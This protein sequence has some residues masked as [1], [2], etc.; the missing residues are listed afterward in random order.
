MSKFFKSM[1]LLLSAGLFTA[2]GWADVMYFNRLA[3]TGSIAEGTYRDLTLENP[4]NATTFA[5]NTT[6]SNTAESGEIGGSYT[7]LLVSGVDITTHTFMGW[8]KI[9]ALPTSGYQNLWLVSNTQGTYGG[10]KAAVTPEGKIAF[11]RSGTGWGFNDSNTPYVTTTEVCITADTW[12]HIALVFEKSSSARTATC[13]LYVNGREVSL[14][15]SFSDTGCN[16]NASASV[17]IA[18]GVSAAGIY[19][20][21]TVMSLDDIKATAVSE[22]Y[23]RYITSAVSTTLSSN[24]DWSTTF[25]N[26]TADTDLTVNVDG[27]VTLTVNATATVNSLTVNEGSADGE[28]SLIIANTDANKLT[29]TTTTINADT[30]VEAGAASLGVATIA[31][32]KT[33][34]VKEG[35]FT[36]NDNISNGSKLA[37]AGTVALNLG[38]ENGLTLDGNG[39]GTFSGAV[40]VLSGTLTMTGAGGSGFLTGRTV[41]VLDGAA[42]TI[43]DDN[44]TGHGNTPANSI[45]HVQQGGTLN[46]TSR[47]SFKSTL[48]LTGGAVNLTGGD[49]AVGGIK[50]TLDWM[51]DGDYL[52]VA[53]LENATAETPTVSK[54]SQKNDCGLALRSALGIVVEAKAKL[55]IEAPIVDVSAGAVT[56][57]GL[58]VLEL[59]G[60]NTS[61]HDL[62]VEAGQM[63]LSGAW[64]GALSVNAEA[65]LTYTTSAA[66]TNTITNNNNGTITA[67]AATV[68]LTGATISGNG[69]YGVTNGGTLILK[70]G[71]ENGA[72]VTRGTLKLLLSPEQLI[73]G[74]TADVADGTVVTF[75]KVK[76]GAEEY[77]TLAEGVTKYGLPAKD[78]L[79]LTATVGTGDGQVTAWSG[80]A[81]AYVYKNTTLSIHFTANNQTFTFDNT[82]GVSLTSLTVTAEDGVTGAKIV[83]PATEGLVIATA[84]TINAD[85]TVTGKGALG[86]VT[87]AEG[88]TLTVSE[89]YENIISSLTNNGSLAFAGTESAPLQYASNDGSVMSW[90]KYVATHA[91]TYTFCGYV[92]VEG[93]YSEGS[94]D[95]RKGWLRFQA[96]PQTINIEDGANITATRL[97]ASDG[98]NAATTINQDGGTIT[99]KSTVV[100]GSDNNDTTGN[101][102]LLGHWP[103]TTTYNLNAG[104]LL[105][106]DGAL[107]LGWDGPAHLTIGQDSGNKPALVS[108]KRLSG[109]TRS[110]DAS[111]TIKRTGTL[112]I[113]DRGIQLASSKSFT[114]AGGTLEMAANMAANNEII[115]L[116]HSAGLK[117]TKD[118]TIVVVENVKIAYSGKI[119]G[120]SNTLTKMGA[121][122]LNLVNASG[123]DTLNYVVNGGT[124][125][126]PAG[127][128]NGASVTRGTLKLL[129][130]PELLAKG[131]TANVANG[132]TVTFVVAGNADG[133]GDGYDT[134][135]EGVA[136]N[137]Y[138]AP[139]NVWTPSKDATWANTLNWSNEALPSDT[140]NVEIQIAEDTTLVLPGNVTVAALR[141]T[142]TG[143]LTIT[144][145]KLTASFID[146]QAN[147]SA[148]EATLALVPMEISENVRVTYTMTTADV[149]LPAM[150]GAGTF[151]KSGNVTTQLNS[152]IAYPATIEV[153]EGKLL[154]RD[155]TYALASHV[156]AKE[157]TTVQVGTLAAN[158]TASAST[159]R[160]EGGATLLLENG[161]TNG[162]RNVATAITID[163]SIAG[164]PAVIKGSRQGNQANITGPISGKGVLEILQHHNSFTI[165]GVISDA[166][167]TETLAVKVNTSVGVTFSGSNTYTGGTEIATGAKLTTAIASLP[168]DITLQEGAVLI[169]NTAAGTATDF[170]TRTITVTPSETVGDRALIVRQNALNDKSTNTFVMSGV[171][172][173]GSGNLVLA[174]KSGNASTPVF[175]TLNFAEGTDFS[176]EISV[177]NQFDKGAVV[178]VVGNCL[179][180]ATYTFASVNGYNA[181]TGGSTF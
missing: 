1:F 75:V 25:Q 127:K 140:D 95:A 77:E 160:L 21:S 17:Y 11:G 22:T 49:N 157:G 42:V 36:N 18:S 132:T 53:A 105:A 78:G 87:I 142:G 181:Q 131:Y 27:A 41:N 72:S 76:A 55:V 4:V 94:D 143:T 117:I 151:V 40:D 176:G 112:R 59:A 141:V 119:T 88:K 137:K 66:P 171:T 96:N 170:R 149:Q 92:N 13:T 79:T 129:L 2:T 123:L 9:A 173:T 3:G 65:M 168:G 144:G 83:F 57:K 122:E 145:G 58:G 37:G 52:Q 156:V 7:G 126:L 86:A 31:N 8:F 116:P 166:S 128:E 6:L 26:T 114:L 69:T 50:R 14:T 12:C 33:L 43:G 125:I 67:D 5:S 146:A 91:G 121:G 130:S 81:E 56:K 74:Y 104:S 63:I 178:T 100:E 158:L 46:F 102:I 147:I 16:G 71:T 120:E 111:I 152:S 154:F 68:D 118:S 133:D 161:N 99:L 10:Y 150:T 73:N 163:S 44:A 34:T 19:V 29:V 109:T 70:A 115:D 98:P 159:L 30:T 139:M 32:T 175:Q 48:K 64:A 45:L 97:L 80:V 20:D 15:G 172:L 103:A 101:A 47:N 28:K 124:L 138:A 82:F 177:Y 85:V 39:A 179:A 169:D 51:S 60:Q 23:V 106:E 167:E 84:T 108:V 165:S 107:N 61:S 164:K 24:A 62:T 153:A 113:G 89:A 148:S 162:A 155:E 135:I 136:G 38:A 93:G 174:G 35:Y 180:K 110:N 134:L 54:I 90:A